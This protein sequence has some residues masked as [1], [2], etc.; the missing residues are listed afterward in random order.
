MSYILRHR[1]CVEVGLSVKFEI[2]WILGLNNLFNGQK[3]Y[4]G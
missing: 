1:D 4:G 3:S 2:M